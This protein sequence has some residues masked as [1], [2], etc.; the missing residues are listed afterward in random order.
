M[1]AIIVEA[2]A[3]EQ[4]IHAEGLLERGD[5]G[6]R[7]THTDE[8]GGPAPLLLQRLCGAHDVLRF[9]IECDGLGAT[10][11]DEFDAA[12]RGQTLRYE[13]ADAL[14]YFLRIL[15]G[16]EPAGDLHASLRGDDRLG[17]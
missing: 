4:A 10:T 2:K 11:T 13:A 14:Q 16:H 6:D 7:A 15:A 17:T 5:D 8:R 9:G 12:I 3:H 1:D